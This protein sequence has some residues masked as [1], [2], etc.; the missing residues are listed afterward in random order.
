MRVLSDINKST[1][2]QP[3]FRVARGRSVRCLNECPEGDLNPH[4]RK[5]H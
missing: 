2:G 1:P 5:G 4:A 3:R